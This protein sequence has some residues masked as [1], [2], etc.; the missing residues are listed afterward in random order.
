MSHTTYQIVEA[1]RAALVDM[2]ACPAIRK[3]A[4]DFPE[5]GI[6]MLVVASRRFNLHPSTVKIQTARARA[7]SL[8]PVAAPLVKKPL[9]AKPAAPVSDYKA[10]ARAEI[11]RC[12]EIARVRWGVAP[13][14]HVTWEK[15]GVSAGSAR[16]SS[17]ISLHEHFASKEGEGYRSTVAHEYAHC[18][19]NA[20]RPHDAAP[21]RR[22]LGLSLT[23]KLMFAKQRRDSQWSSHGSKWKEVMRS[24][25]HAPRRCHNYESTEEIRRPRYEVKCPCRIHRVSMTLLNR[26]RAGAAYRCKQC[27]GTLALS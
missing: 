8:P 26:I 18:V 24:F 3:V 19:V 13:D 15:R 11:D 16:G 25:G 7:V 4:T 17:R 22:L 10:A 1:F 6:E 14:P 2:K 9:A 27:K 23:G 21:T 12:R 5:A 20:M